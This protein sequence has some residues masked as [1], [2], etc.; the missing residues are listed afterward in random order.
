[1]HA[2]TDDLRR[3]QMLEA[4]R[5]RHA[6]KFMVYDQSS[7]CTTLRDSSV[8]YAAAVVTAAPHVSQEVWAKMWVKEV[9]AKVHAFRNLQICKVSLKPPPN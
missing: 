5:T 8:S 3:L 6:V 7:R 4:C 9:W 1:M 2:V